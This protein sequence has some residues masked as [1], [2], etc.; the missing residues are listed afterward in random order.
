MLGVPPG[1]DASATSEVVPDGRIPDDEAPGAEALHTAPAGAPMSAGG[2][3]AA[4][5][6]GNAKRIALAAPVCCAAATAAWGVTPGAAYG[7]SPA[8]QRS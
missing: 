4:S 6:P 3:R 2:C 1:A 7:P 8:L 5:G